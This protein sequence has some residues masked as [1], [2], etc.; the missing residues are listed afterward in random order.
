MHE[1]ALWLAAAALNVRA[2]GSI[3]LPEPQEIGELRLNFLRLADGTGRVKLRIIRLC[4]ILA[5]MAALWAIAL[6]VFQWEALLALAAAG[7]LDAWASALASLTGTADLWLWLYLAFVIA[8]TMFPTLA[9][10]SDKR[11]KAIVLFTAP[12][13]IFVLWRFAGIAIP[14]SASSIEALVSSLGLVV[15]QIAVLNCCAL[16]VLG[17][18][19]ALIERVTKRS[20]AFRDGVMITMSREEAQAFKLNQYRA[21]RVPQTADDKPRSA[22]PLDSIY[23]VK[24]PIPGPPGKEP[25]SRSAVAVVN[26]DSEKDVPA[27]ASAAPSETSAPVMRHPTFDKERAAENIEAEPSFARPKNHEDAPFARPFVAPDVPDSRRQSWQ[28]KTDTASAN[29]D[30]D[31][32]L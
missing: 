2:E 10:R 8:N 31:T 26:L 28:A 1:L 23:D 32:E 17:A 6:H 30:E 29:A 22:P 16:A 4:P 25:V 20:A 9:L 19:E 27:M 12:L 13:L 21:S 18:M 11:E 24:L 5:G 15:G 14:A 3:S 7:T